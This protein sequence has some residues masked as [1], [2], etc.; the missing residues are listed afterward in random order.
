ML[1]QHVH[2]PRKVELAQI[3]STVAGSQGQGFG[4][5]VDPGVEKVADHR[6]SHLESRNL[7]LILPIAIPLPRTV[8]YLDIEMDLKSSLMPKHDEGFVK[9]ATKTVWRHRH[10][11]HR[12][13][14]CC[15]FHCSIIG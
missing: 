6:L 15:L 12:S 10:D 5:S 11:D 4:G 7:R 14:G 8:E 2:V 1:D 9:T 3:Y 13:R